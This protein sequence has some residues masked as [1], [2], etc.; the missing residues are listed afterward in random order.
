MEVHASNAWSIRSAATPNLIAHAL[1]FEGFCIVVVNS[2]MAELRVIYGCLSMFVL[3]TCQL[4]IVFECHV[5][6]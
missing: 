5:Y 1:A 4:Q 3:V 6:K 2:A